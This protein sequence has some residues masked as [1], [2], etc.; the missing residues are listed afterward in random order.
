M[1][2][3][4]KNV[5]VLLMCMVLMMS[6]LTGCGNNDPTAN[7]QTQQTEERLDGVEGYP[8]TIT[9][10]F[11]KEVTLQKE[12]MR[13]VSIAP[14][15][16]E[17]IYAIGGEEKLVG[18][19][20]YCDY[21]E[22][23]SEIESVGPITPVDIEKIISLEPDLVITSTHVYGEQSEKLEEAGIPIIGLYEV[24][25]VEG[26]YTMLDTLGM[27]LNKQQEAEKVVQ[28]M[29]T[30]IEEVQTKVA[31][32]EKPTVYYVV[33]YGEYGDFSAPENTSIG[34]MI[35]LAGGKDIVPA[36]ESWSYSLEALLAAD[37]DIIV[38]R[39]GDKEGFMSAAGYNELTAVKEGH[40]YEI[41]NNLID[42]QSN[43]NAEG[44]LELAKIF[45]P[46]AFQS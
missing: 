25:K 45:H 20:D 10:S 37:P 23:V 15:V 16:T 34:E 19:T 26:V 30:T 2:K 8:L 4:L 12:P 17:M 21:P 14:S 31:S 6:V 18:R 44:I 9:D 33:G 38:I 42:R 35:E 22:Q 24:D 7:H 5:S 43:R 13:I 39:N 36:S 41:D 3:V 27:I 46:E 28:E 32:L 11:G 40:V 1:R 29:K